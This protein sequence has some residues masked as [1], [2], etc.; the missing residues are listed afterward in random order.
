M[1]Q[2]FMYQLVDTL[3]GLMGDHFSELKAQ[4]EHIT[5]IVRIEEEK[6]IKTLDKGLKLLDDAIAKL[7]AEQILSGETLFTLYDTFG[8]PLD[9]TQDILRDR[10]IQ[11]DVQGFNQCMQEQ[12]VR[13]R[14]AWTGSGESSVPAAVF[15]LHEEHGATQFIGYEQTQSPAMILA[16]LQGQ[17]PKVIL[18]EGEEAWLFCNP[19]PFYAE[20]GGQV[21]DSG[22]ISTATGRFLVHKTIKTL[23]DVF[24]HVGVVQEGSIEV[25]QAAD[26]VVDA[27]RRAAICH[28]HT[29]THLLHEQLRLVLGEHVK[30]AGSLVNAERLRFDFNHMEPMS[31]AE[32]KDVEGRVNR[33][34]WQNHVLNSQCMTPDE[35]VA[36]GAMALFGEKYG[37]EVRV[38]TA[39]T[40]VELCGGTHVQS[41]GD[42]GLFRILS[43][44]GIA[45][46]VRRIEAITGEQAYQQSLLEQAQLQSIGQQLRVAPA[47]SVARVQQL[48]EKLKA[49]EKTLSALQARQASSSLDDLITQAVDCAGTK[50]LAVQIPP[51]EGV[52]LRDLMDKCKSKLKSGVIVLA[53]VRGEKV[54]L[55]AGVTK[56]LVKQ[57]HAGK[58]IRE[59]A[60]KV[61]G[62]G[63]GRPDMAQAGGTQ[64]EHVAKAL[65]VIPS[66]MLGH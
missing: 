12:R 51:Q 15:S 1:K 35:A 39:G 59:V 19:T 6:F 60:E 34:V 28:N 54:Q 7:G 40:S 23:P 13:A 29:A 14:S 31:D 65:A 48:Q 30:Q 42:I 44:V 21:G 56:D 22:M 27:S 41:L 43:E 55:I 52:D 36:Q 32:V 18:Q 63:G 61:G 50:L 49:T 53:M 37:D 10:A 20:S 25:H 3:V 45:S 17:E 26:C 5:R 2:A 57:F 47:D 38:V 4:Q 58:I 62:R 24:A 46:G 66:L 16:L 64:P 11:L 33:I 9:S 8:F